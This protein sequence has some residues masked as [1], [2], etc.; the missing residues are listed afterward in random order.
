MRDM[1]QLISSHGFM[2]F[3]DNAI[4][5]FSIWEHTPPELRFSDEVDGPW[6]WKGP[7]ILDGGYAYGK[8]LEAKAM[9]VTMEWFPH[10]A[11]WRRSRATITSQEQAVLDTIAQHHSLLTGQLRKLCGY[12]RAHQHRESNP[13]LRE[14]DRLT[15][16]IAKKPKP[17]VEGLETCLTHLQMNT[18]I[19][20]ADFEYKVDKRGQRYGWGVARYCTPEDFFGPETLLT[21]CAPEQSRRLLEQHLSQVLPTATTAQIAAIIG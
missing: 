6:E 20:I 14:S 10:L 9:Y 8:L 7:V 21:G 11:N 5:G 15:R 1:E 18:Y 19:I 3:F 17:R 2:P 16:K 4:P 12:S 13:L